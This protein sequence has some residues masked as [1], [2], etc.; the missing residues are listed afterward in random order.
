MK[1]PFFG[2]FMGTMVLILLGNG[3]VANVLLKRSKA[4]GSGWMVITT[5]WA[6]A[7]MA[8]RFPPLPSG[9]RDAHPEPAVTIGLAVYSGQF[10]KFTPYLVAQMAGAFVGAVLV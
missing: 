1:T 5:G 8:G 2:E 4:E 9:R 7:V 6:F 10:A 3:V